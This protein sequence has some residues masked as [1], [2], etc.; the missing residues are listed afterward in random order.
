MHL[1]QDDSGACQ[2]TNTV[3]GSDFGDAPTF[4]NASATASLPPDPNNPGKCDPPVNIDKKLL[5]CGSDGLCHYRV[6]IKN[7]GA[8]PLNYTVGF[9]D[10]KGS[11][12]G[13]RAGS[14]L[15]PVS[16]QPDGQGWNCSPPPSANA[17]CTIDGVPAGQSRWVDV[18]VRASDL[19]GAP[20]NCADLVANGRQVPRKRACAAGPPGAP[21]WSA[22]PSTAGTTP[23]CSDQWRRRPDGTCCPHSMYWSDSA[24]ACVSGNPSGYP[25][26]TS[27]ATGAG[28]SGP[29]GSATSGTRGVQPNSV[30]PGGWPTGSP[31][32]YAS[33]ST[34]GTLVGPYGGAVTTSCPPGWAWNP[35]RRICEQPVG[36]PP[37]GSATGG[38]AGVLPST[39]NC[40]SGWTWDARRRGCEPPAGVSQG[41]SAI[42]GTAGA[43][44]S[45][46]NCPS[47]WTWNA[48]RRGCE[49]P[50]GRPPSGSASSGTARAQ[51]SNNRCAYGWIRH[52]G[53]LTCAPPRSP[54]GGAPTGGR[55]AGLSGQTTGT[56]RTSSCAPG[57][58]LKYGRCIPGARTSNAPTWQGAYRQEPYGPG[59]AQYGQ[60]SFGPG[61]VSY[62]QAPFGPRRASYGQAQHG[63]GRW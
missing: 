37:G 5:S 59:R 34:A 30:P 62:G 57:M 17:L 16:V 10:Q 33:P 36:V 46:P 45:T 58:R 19:A 63:P 35:R 41:G 21:L 8:G 54:Q 9:D 48:R 14:K 61:R 12:S 29:S 55:D 49:P 51:P 11:P 27:T 24:S 50:A 39:P 18:T 6:M 60:G 53:R 44:P 23:V 38:T 7:N 25:S 26:P 32:G 13:P 43:L 42:G 31:P 56:A 4:I 28:L 47:G 52:A 2:V 40:P 1:P 3:S 20:G 15:T 22:Q